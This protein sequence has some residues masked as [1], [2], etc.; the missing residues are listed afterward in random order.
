MVTLLAHAPAWASLVAVLMVV[1]L[2]PPTEEFLFRGVLLHGLGVSYGPRLAAILVTAVFVIGHLP[3]VG[4]DWAAL[5]VHVTVAV[6]LLAARVST[7]SLLPP[8]AMHAAY[9]S[10]LFVF[11]YFWMR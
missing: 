10:G 2:A 11:G 1:A 9:N 5:F 3:E 7:G 8:L 6:S 4:N